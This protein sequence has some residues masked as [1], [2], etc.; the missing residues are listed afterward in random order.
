MVT[1]YESP[2]VAVVVYYSAGVR[3]RYQ[4]EHKG[5]SSV[6]GIHPDDAVAIA[7]EILR[8]EGWSVGRL[9]KLE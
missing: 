1:L 9:V 6:A 2:R 3:R 8:M 7:R 5:G 4:I